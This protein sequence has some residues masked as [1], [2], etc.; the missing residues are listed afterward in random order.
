ME[1]LS[2]KVVDG[3]KESVSFVF[4]QKNKP[5]DAGRR[6]RSCTRIP[7]NGLKID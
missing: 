6:I 5:A 7:R 2:S 1:E 4:D 3:K